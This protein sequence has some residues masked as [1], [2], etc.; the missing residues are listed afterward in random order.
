MSRNGGTLRRQSEVK[1]GS[2]GMVGHGVERQPGKLHRFMVTGAS[3]IQS[4]S[5]T[6]DSR[7]AEYN[8]QRISQIS[9][10]FFPRQG[11]LT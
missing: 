5:R 11:F 6:K 9:H 8:V 10:I 7:H 4:I 1:V 3:V 2:E